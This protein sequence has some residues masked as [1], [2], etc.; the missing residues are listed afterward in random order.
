MKGLPLMVTEHEMV[1][2]TLTDRKGAKYR[3]EFD[4]VVHKTYVYPEE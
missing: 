4:P 3:I 2:G 1:P